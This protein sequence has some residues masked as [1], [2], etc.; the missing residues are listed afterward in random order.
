MSCSGS[1][2]INSKTLPLTS[3]VWHRSNKNPGKIV[4]ALRQR[5]VGLK[6]VAHPY[7][8]RVRIEEKYIGQPVSILPGDFGDD[9]LGFLVPMVESRRTLELKQDGLPVDALDLRLLATAQKIIVCGPHH[10]GISVR[11]HN[12]E[13]WNALTGPGKGFAGDLEL[14][15]SFAAERDRILIPLR[16]VRPARQRESARTAVAEIPHDAPYRVLV[17]AQGVTYRVQPVALR[18][19]REQAPAPPARCSCP[20]RS[21]RSAPSTA[22]TPASPPRGSS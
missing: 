19:P 2:S 21:R 1:A 22:R 11:L 8:R 15:V 20:K 13:E 12:I 5:S 17:V 6:P 16:M 7:R 3:F 10:S 18:H 4:S 9:F 14:V